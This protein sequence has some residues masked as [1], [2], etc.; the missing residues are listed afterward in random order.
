VVQPHRCDAMWFDRCD[1]VCSCDVMCSGLAATGRGGARLSGTARRPGAD[2]E[3]RPGRDLAVD[4]ARP[5]RRGLAAPVRCGLA[6]AM[7]FGYRA[8]FSLNNSQ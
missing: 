3:R 2:L 1:V 8:V 4:L 6:D 5:C 7:W